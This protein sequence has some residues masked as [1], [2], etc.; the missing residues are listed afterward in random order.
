MKEQGE[1]RTIAILGTT[2]AAVFAA[3]PEA[4]QTCAP[5]VQYS[6]AVRL[7]TRLNASFAPPQKI[8]ISTSRMFAVTN[9]LS[10]AHLLGLIW[11]GPGSEITSPR[12]P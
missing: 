1:Y 7:Q 11:F 4:L 3:D 12:H 5:A 2:L 10:L 9:T 6:L 8:R